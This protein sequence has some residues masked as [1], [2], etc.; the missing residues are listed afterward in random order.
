MTEWTCLYI[1]GTGIRSSVMDS[2]R[3]RSALNNVRIC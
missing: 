2:I 3:S 1:S